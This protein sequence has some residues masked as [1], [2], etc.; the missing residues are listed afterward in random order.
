MKIIILKGNEVAAGTDLANASALSGAQ[1]VKHY[2]TAASTLTCCVER[3]MM[4][5]VQLTADMG[6]TAQATPTW[7]RCL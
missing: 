1:L 5:G 3:Q 4:W 6:G 7:P 2:H